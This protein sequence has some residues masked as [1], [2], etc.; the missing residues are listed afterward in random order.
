MTSSG[1]IGGIQGIEG[2]GGSGQ[3]GKWAILTLANILAASWNFP[4]CASTE[5]IKAASSWVGI[6]RCDTH[7]MH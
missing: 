3:Q 7:T 6:L 4:W 1:G 5:A 2:I